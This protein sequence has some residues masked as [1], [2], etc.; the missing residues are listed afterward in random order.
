MKVYFKLN[1]QTSS[2][3]PTVKLLFEIAVKEVGAPQNISA[4]LALV[5][6]RKIKQLNKTYRNID[7]V[8]DVLS[9][10]MVDN[11]DQI[12]SEQDFDIGLCNV[13]DIYIN[14]QRA[15]Q[16]AAEYGHSLKREFCFLAL[17]G[18]LH[19]LGYD[20]IEKQDEKVMFELQDK[21]MKKAN[22]GRD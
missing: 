5:G 11:F 10:P 16:Q 22:V 19:L 2:Y 20:H 12:E 1:N 15:Q 21:I 17:H 4:N 7:K 18:F 8:T 14:L 13:G 6:E 3:K 9:F